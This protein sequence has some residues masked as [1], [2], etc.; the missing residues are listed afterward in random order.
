[1]PVADGPFA[2]PWRRW[3]W[4]V[5]L[6]GLLV[7]ATGAAMT[8]R[9][10]RASEDRLLEQQAR[11]AGAV[12][13]GAIAR[14]ETAVA[15]TA[16]LVDAT[17]ADAQEFARFERVLVAD[18]GFVGAHVVGADGEVVATSSTGPLIGPPE[19]PALVAALIDRARNDPGSIRVALVEGTARRVAYAT[20]SRQ[21]TP[22][23]VYAESPL[24]DEPT[25]LGRSDGPFSDIDYALSLGGGSDT[26]VL[27]YASTDE[28]PL[29]GTT[30][31]VDLPLGD[32][33]LQFTARAAVPLSG[34]FAQSAPYVL[35]LG[36][37][38]VSVAAAL[39]TRAV[40]RRGRAAERLATELSRMTQQQRAGIETLR[41]SLLPQRLSV[42]PGVLVHTGFW[43]A[44]RDS[45]I[46]GDFYDAFQVDDRRWAVVIG[47]VCGKGAEAAALTGLTRHTIRAAARHLASPVEVLRWTHEAIASYGTATYVT[48]CFAFLDVTDDGLH[49][50]LSLGGHPRP[51]LWR[52]GEV[53]MI[54]DRGTLLGLVEPTLTTTVEH[55]VPGDVLLLYT[56]GLTDTPVAPLDDASLADLVATAL[57]ACDPEGCAEAIHSELHRLRP[58]GS[59]DDSALLLLHVPDRS[60]SPIDADRSEPASSAAAVRTEA[61][62]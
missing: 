57:T 4:V 40:L 43:P 24:P 50:A 46:S 42:P 17:D 41:R 33:R 56:D 5:L 12:L 45:E 54:G 19:Q 27:L 47:D 44:D 51:A 16:R 8:W 6:A 20:T 22:H 1:M 10:Y 48:V 39:G 28:V 34:R 37:T 59:S 9:T 23:V 25:G 52:G 21:P 53:R 31:T 36:G 55:L 7:T 14:T 61:G 29:T 2:T 11:E 32:L 15:N 26:P 35:A 3:P 18:H 30:T 60:T 49:V 13:S 58:Q 62:P 38:L